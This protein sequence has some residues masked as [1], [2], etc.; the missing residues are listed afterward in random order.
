MDKNIVNFLKNRKV[1]TFATSIDG[2]PYCAHCFFA[3]DFDLST[4]I[5]LSDEK[6][7]H[8]KEACKNNLVAGTIN[9]ENTSVAKLQGIQFTG[10]FIHPD[11]NMTESLYDIYFKK[12]PFA[13]AKP[14]HV[15]AVELHTIKMTDNT[16]GFGTKHLWV[17]DSA[18]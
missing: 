3:F 11:I 13:R 18:I 15:W 7:R 16:L 1:M 12:Y 8:I 17:K 14:S 4:L 2:Q 9:A 6:T 5:F 10:K